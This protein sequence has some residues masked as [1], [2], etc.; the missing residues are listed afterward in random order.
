MTRCE[1]K[2]SR[3][4]GFGEVSMH[5]LQPRWSP[6][7]L[8]VFKRCGSPGECWLHWGYNEPKLSKIQDIGEY[9]NL[10]FGFCLNV[11]WDPAVDM[12]LSLSFLEKWKKLPSRT[13]ASFCSTLNRCFRGLAQPYRSWKV[14]GALRKHKSMKNQSNTHQ[15]IHWNISKHTRKSTRTSIQNQSTKPMIMPWGTAFLLLFY[16][17]KAWR[18]KRVALVA[19]C[20]WASVWIVI[21]ISWFMDSKKTHLLP[22]RSSIH[23]CMYI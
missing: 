16:L 15:Q 5:S 22:I 20:A 12:C 14:L 1:S 11:H 17:V 8:E 6:K 9:L 18:T 19:P 23:M 21:S 2:M 13:V 7:F 4:T 3:Q 10:L